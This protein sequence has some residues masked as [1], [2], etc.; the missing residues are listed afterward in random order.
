MSAIQYF[1]KA[2]RVRMHGAE[3]KSNEVTLPDELLL[4]KKNK[5]RCF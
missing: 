5:K 3:E 1:M 2:G 4:R